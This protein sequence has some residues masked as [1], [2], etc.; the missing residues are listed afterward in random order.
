MLSFGAEENSPFA[1][2]TR[3]VAAAWLGSPC[4]FLHSFVPET[5]RWQ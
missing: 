1:T 2:L 5:Q 3:W 4:G